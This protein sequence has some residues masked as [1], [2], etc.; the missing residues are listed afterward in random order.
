MRWADKTP[1]RSKQDTPPSRRHPAGAPAACCFVMAW[2]DLG[3]P[4]QTGEPMVLFPPPPAPVSQIERGVL[5]RNETSSASN[6]KQPL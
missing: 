1:P 2:H 3:V 6:H 5:S 4:A